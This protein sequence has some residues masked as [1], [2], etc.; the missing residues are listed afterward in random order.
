MTS[1]GTLK[2]RRVLVTGGTRGIGLA[3][4]RALVREGA[5]VVTCYHRDQAAAGALAAEFSGAAEPP[6]IVRADVTDPAALERLAAS[7]AEELD[8][9]DVVVNNVGVDG[10]APL[11]QLERAEWD[12]VLRTDLTGCYLVVQAVLGLLGEGASI[13][14]VGASGALRGRPAAAHH[15]A[16]KAA[17]IGLTR[18]LA[19]E[20]GPRGIRVNTVAPGPVHDP[21]APSLPPRALAGIRGMAALG[22]LAEPRD[23][24]DAVLYLAGDGARCVSGV[25]LNVDGGM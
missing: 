19:K 25:T 12:R 24:A 10:S 21:D 15:G 23:V 22:R 17:L 14:N 5:R 16:A 4:V 20:L 3:T 13:V 11:A 9:L 18:S 6:R 2:D 1:G 7:C 8:G